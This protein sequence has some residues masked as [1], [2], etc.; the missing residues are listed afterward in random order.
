VQ[1]KVR[2][3]LE[4]LREVKLSFEQEGSKIIYNNE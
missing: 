4:E 2:R 3:A 1:N